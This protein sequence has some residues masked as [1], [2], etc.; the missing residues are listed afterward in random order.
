MLFIECGALLVMGDMG[1]RGPVIG[2]ITTNSKMLLLLTANIQYLHWQKESSEGSELKSQGTPTQD[3]IV[4]QK[5]DVIIPQSQVFKSQY[6]T[7][8]LEAACVCGTH[9]TPS[10]SHLATRQSSWW[11]M[12]NHPRLWEA[13]SAQPTTLKE[14][15][16]QPHCLDKA[17]MMFNMFPNR[18]FRFY[19]AVLA[20]LSSHQDNSLRSGNK[21][22]K[23]T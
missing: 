5:Q 7:F 11:T 6:G 12:M 20:W 17:M 14:L 21:V 9:H 16:T 23:N 19:I 4:A 8:C 22:Q 3:L 13:A 18:L 10:L 1:F 2:S 15:A